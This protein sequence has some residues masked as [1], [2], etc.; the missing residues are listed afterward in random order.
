MI[1]ASSIEEVR[2]QLADS[3]NQRIVLA[4][5]EKFNRAV[6]EHLKPSALIMNHAQQKQDTLR[7][8]DLPVNDVSAR[9]AVKNSVAIGFDLKT[10]RL[11]S[12]EAQA[13]ELARIADTIALCRKTQTKL[14]L[15][16]TTTPESAHAFLR[17]L[18]ASTEQASQAVVL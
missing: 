6:L 4:Q 14:A 7:A 16:N 11:L 15:F 5:D 18:G 13:R 12:T 10:L 17:A 1:T 9:I 8:L 2:K 3:R